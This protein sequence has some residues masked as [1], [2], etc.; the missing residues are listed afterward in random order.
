M[1]ACRR[2]QMASHV[3]RS[4]PVVAVGELL[5]AASAAGGSILTTHSGHLA[6]PSAAV[7]PVAVTAVAVVYGAYLSDTLLRKQLQTAPPGML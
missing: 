1:E 5:A 6:I 2:P 4:L 7:T 3:A